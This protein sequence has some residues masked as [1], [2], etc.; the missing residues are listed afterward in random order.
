MYWNMQ[1]PDMESP[2]PSKFMKNSLTLCVTENY[3]E[4]IKKKSKAYKYVASDPIC[5]L[6]LVH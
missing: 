3:T 2:V 5:T 1:A 4:K 6:A